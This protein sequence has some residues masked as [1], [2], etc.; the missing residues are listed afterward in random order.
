MPFICTYGAS[1]LG[2]M[3]LK[4]FPVAFPWVAKEKEYVCSWFL[5]VYCTYEPVG[6]AVRQ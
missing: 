4:T 3:V 5:E 6:R 1:N 2:G